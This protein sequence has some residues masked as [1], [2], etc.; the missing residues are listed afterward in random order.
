MIERGDGSI[1]K[2]LDARRC[3]RCTSDWKPLITDNAEICKICAFS[4]AKTVETDDQQCG[5]SGK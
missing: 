2:L 4:I 5:S 1:Q 3:P